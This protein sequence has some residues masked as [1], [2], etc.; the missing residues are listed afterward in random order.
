MDV[1]AK[2]DKFRQDN[3]VQHPPDSPEGKLQ[4]VGKYAFNLESEIESQHVKL[5]EHG[6]LTDTGRSKQ[7]Q[8][9][10][11]MNIGKLESRLP[12][13]N[14]AIEENTALLQTGPAL[15]A[16][17]VEFQEHILSDFLSK[18][19]PQ[20]ALIAATEAT[21][22]PKLASVLLRAGKRLT[23]LTDATEELLRASLF[24]DEEKTAREKAA[25]QLGAA[26]L[27]SSRVARSIETM[28]RY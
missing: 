16:A 14:E 27:A 25:R 22:E 13:I 28:R 12:R 3:E 8:P 10:V 24:S 21:R 1:R 2:I 17:P 15:T 23:G 19:G 9:L 6:D 5:G 20:R 18:S 26:Q 7:L 11:E 4:A